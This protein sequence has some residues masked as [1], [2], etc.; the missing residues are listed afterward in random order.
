[1]NNMLSK[2]RG[3]GQI[4]VILILAL[5]LRVIFALFIFTPEVSKSDAANFDQIAWNLRCGQG[6]SLSPP[7]PAIDRPPLFTFFLALIYFLFGHSHAAVR[8]AQG[9]VGSLTCAVVYIIGKNIFDKTIGYWAAFIVAV[10]PLLIGMTTF[11]LS[12]VL[13]AFLVSLSLLP[14][15]HLHQTILPT[16]YGAQSRSSQP[17]VSSYPTPRWA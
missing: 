2:V 15:Y 17:S 4:L 8:V 13:C 6:Y 9:I 14:L 11:L 1:M 3:K 7:E 5:F 16:R 10:H 12:E